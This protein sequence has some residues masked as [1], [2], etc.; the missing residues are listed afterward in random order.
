MGNKQGGCCWNKRDDD[1]KENK[2]NNENDDTYKPREKSLDEI[3]DISKLSNIPPNLN[4]SIIEEDNL[5]EISAFESTEFHKN[6]KEIS[7]PKVHSKND[8]TLNFKNVFINLY[9]TSLDIKCFNIDEYGTLIKPFIEISIDKGTERAKIIENINS[10]INISKNASYS[11]LYNTK[12]I[13]NS[14]SVLNMSSLNKNNLSSKHYKEKNF[15]FKFEKQYKINQ[16]QSFST[17][18]FTVKN[19]NGNFTTESNPNVII[20]SNYISLRCLIS[21]YID[22]EFDGYLEIFNS[23]NSLVG[24]LKICI[25]IKSKD[26]SNF[27]SNIINLE[28]DNNTYNNNSNNQNNENSINIYK[29]KYLHYEYLDETTIDKHFVFDFK[30][31]LTHIKEIQDLNLEFLKPIHINDPNKFKIMDFEMN[32]IYDIYIKILNTKNMFLCHSL[33][34]LLNKIIDSDTDLAYELIYND[35]LKKIENVNQNEL[36]NNNVNNE[37]E[38]KEKDTNKNKN[39]EF[40]LIYNIPSISYYNFFILK[41]YYLF[42]TRYIR[43]FKKNTK[44]KFFDYKI[45][46]LKLS[47]TIK[48]INIS[49]KSPQGLSESYKIEMGSV[50]LLIMELCLELCTYNEEK[51]DK[52]FDKNLEIFLQIFSNS[53]NILQKQLVI[54]KLVEKFSDNSLVCSALT[55]LFR[56]LLQ[57]LLTPIK[58]NDKANAIQERFKIK[59]ED[60]SLGIRKLLVEESEGILITSLKLIF[61]KFFHFPEIHLNINL[62]LISLTSHLKESE[63]LILFSIADKFDF[64][65]LKSNF[66]IFRGK[67][68]GLTKLINISHLNLIKNFVSYNGKLEPTAYE[69][70]SRSVFYCFRDY[71][72]T[73]STYMKR[74]SEFSERKLVEVELHEICLNIAYN[75]T[76]HKKMVRLMFDCEFY[77]DLIDYLIVIANG[78]EEET[79]ENST[80]NKD[81]IDK[82]L[83]KRKKKELDPGLMKIIGNIVK[84]STSIILNLYKSGDKEVISEFDKKVS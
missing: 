76:K 63:E 42:V 5:N 27:N 25:I 79:N 71:F 24:L 20:G 78:Y 44:M 51:L 50:V 81:Y 54:L 38:V 41:N 9:I 4:E 8:N 65:A 60:L 74:Y 37:N 2:Q 70:L 30:N 18:N 84:F 40:T 58:Q 62:I 47:D 1:D 19:E 59:Q 39:D 61:S 67:F 21:K 69:M 75:I 22:S 80:I 28:D 26:D 12:D 82:I 52:N 53:M 16:S 45:L 36:Q 10:S 73:D 56:K 46:I 64:D 83:D 17:I 34:I 15:S 33:M 57:F 43:H 32:K 68:V 77:D 13:S 55:R 31:K 48:A 66:R 72:K 3:S 6:T 11:D 14:R 23:Q 49:L 7:V 35:F 29:E